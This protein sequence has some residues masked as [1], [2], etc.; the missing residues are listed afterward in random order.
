M[1]PVSVLFDGVPFESA[2]KLK[3]ND[4][5]VQQKGLL[6]TGETVGQY[7][8]RRGRVLV[9]VKTAAGTSVHFYVE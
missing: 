3:K 5:R 6:A 2:A 1:G 4:T 9:T 7:L 8:Q